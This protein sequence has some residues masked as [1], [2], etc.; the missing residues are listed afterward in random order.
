M[1]R[2]YI[3]IG[4]NLSDPVAQAKT[5]IDALAQIP[6][7]EL[8]T[9]SGLY[10]SRPLGP[11]DQPDY[12]N[13]VAALQTQLA[14]LAL[15]DALQH[16]EQTQGR[17]RK[18]E[19]WGPR[20]LD[21]DILLFGDQLIQCERLTVPHYHMRQREFVI[22]PLAEIAAELEMPDDRTPIKALQ[23]QLPDNGLQRFAYYTPQHC[24]LGK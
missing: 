18:A 14:P 4:S 15:L 19:R 20:S 3:G 6:H 9:V 8:I 5:A 22:T 12:V 11:Q 1:T 7:T 2:C 17:T 21:L 24:Q 10:R 16:I 23:K 13:A